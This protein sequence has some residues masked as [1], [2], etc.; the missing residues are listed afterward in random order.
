MDVGARLHALRSQKKVSQGEIAKRTGVLR[1]HLG[2]TTK[3]PAEK[4]N[5]GND[6]EFRPI[7]VENGDDLLLVF[8]SELVFSLSFGEG[9]ANIAKI[10]NAHQVCSVNRAAHFCHS[11]LQ[12]SPQFQISHLLIGLAH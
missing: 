2:S 7:I 5:V 11:D 1:S 8:A 3:K 10:L 6:G 4:P 12:S 9:G